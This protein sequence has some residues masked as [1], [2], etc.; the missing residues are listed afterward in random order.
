MKTRKTLAALLG[1]LALLALSVPV[2]ASKMDN[3]IESS[4]RK[5]YVFMTYLQGDY[6]K[7]QSRDGVVTLTGQVTARSH[8]ALARETVAG[9][10]GVKN[11][12]DRLQVRGNPKENSDAWL[13]DRVKATLLLQRSVSGAT[14]EVE[15]KD[16]LVVLRGVAESQ[17]QK[18]LT[19]EYAK[20]V[21]GVRE[22][23]N[24]MSVTEPPKKGRTAGEKIDDA[25][26]TS[27]VKMS[28]LYHRSSSALHTE[29]ST[30]R[31]VVTLTGKA[32][33]EAQLNLASKL[34][35]DVHGVKEVRNRMSV[36]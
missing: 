30:K 36:E 14:T 6:I 29:V 28:L 9:L 27:L 5:S 16:G 25:S 10:P 8:K 21:D 19:A 15:V 4:A 22:V 2:F 33:S 31:G 20:D 12:E 24:E 17:A 34:A 32:D 13:R 35:R 26:V 7:V 11:V 18:E 3:R 23:R 1:A